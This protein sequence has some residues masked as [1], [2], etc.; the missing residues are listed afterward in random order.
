MSRRRSTTSTSASTT[1]FRRSRDSPFSLSCYNLDGSNPNYDPASPAC[2][3]ISRDSSGQLLTVATPYQ[4]LGSLKTDG[5][6]FQWHWGLPSLAGRLGGK[7]YLDTAFTW[8]NAYE[9]QLTPGAPF[10]D[11]T[12]VS[13]GGANPNSVPPR[14]TPDLRALTTLGFKGAALGAGLRWRYQ[15]IDG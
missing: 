8:L 1:S 6:E 13:N 5:V 12:G 2:S 9:V 7:F 10:A 11:Y 15:A 4:N 14:A 3:L